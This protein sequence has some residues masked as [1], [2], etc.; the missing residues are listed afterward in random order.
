M[1]NRVF[2]S[3]TPRQSSA[4]S[5]RSG[6]G[7]VKWVGLACAPIRRD[8]QTGTTANVADLSVRSPVAGTVVHDPT[9]GK[10]VEPGEHLFEVADLS[11]LGETAC[12]ATCTRFGGPLVDLRLTAT[13]ETFRSTVRVMGLAFDP[14]SNVNMAQRIRNSAA[15]TASLPGMTG[16]AEIIQPRFRGRVIPAAL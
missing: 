8:P 12:W 3:S 11:S 4:N 10:V 2:K 1:R 5:Q 15:A 16:R 14:L 13:W 9:V 6:R 7:Q